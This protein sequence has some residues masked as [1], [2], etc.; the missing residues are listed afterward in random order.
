M[1]RPWLAVAVL[2]LA[3]I[4]RVTLVPTA[5]QD[6][7][8][9]NW[10]ILCGDAGLAD[11]IANVILFVPVALALRFAGVPAWKIVVGL[12]LMSAAIEIVQLWIPGRESALGDICANTLGAA[13]GVALASW[14]PRRRRS[15]FAALGCA[16]AVLAA[17]GTAGTLLLPR[18]PAEDYYVQWNGDRT[19]YPNYG[20]RVLSAAIGGMPLPWAPLANSEAARERLQRGDT[21]LVRVVAVPAPRWPSQLFGISDV[22]NLDLVVLAVEH[23][24]FLFR[25]HTEAPSLLLREPDLRW[26][27]ALAGTA[28][29]DTLTIAAWRTGRTNCL[30]LN[31]RTRCGVAYATDQVWT[32]I[33]ALP[34]RFTGWG[35][36]VGWAFVALLGLAVGVLAPRSARGGLAV[37]LLLV[38]MA[39][40]PALVG[41]QPLT[42][43]DGGALLAGIVAGLVVPMGGRTRQLHT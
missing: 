33:A 29:G 3:L 14:W 1:R 31:G 41:L 39:V 28:A 11:F 13:L 2:C 37:G 38:G 4:F 25:L 8:V 30:R 40:L 27:H 22:R 16:A 35:T 7:G 42:P 34:L 12:C 23:D 21:L 19:P 36:A 9:F 24:D 20:G 26:P 17:I 10:C 5:D 6:S 43:R 15:A 32:L 18:F